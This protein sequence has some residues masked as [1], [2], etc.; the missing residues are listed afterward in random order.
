LRASATASDDTHY[1]HDNDGHD[2]YDNDDVHY[3]RPDDAYGHYS[4]DTGNSAG[5]RT[6]HYGESQQP[7]SQQSGQSEQ[8]WDPRQSASR[9]CT[10]AR[11]CTAHGTAGLSPGW[12]V[13]GQVRGAGKRLMSTPRFPQ[14]HITETVEEDGLLIEQP[15]S[16]PI[17][18]FCGDIGPSWDYD[19]DT[20]E[21]ETSAG[22]WSGSVNGWAACSPCSDMIEADDWESLLERCLKGAAMVGM[23]DR[24][25][26][27]AHLMHQGF[28]QNRHGE[29]RPWG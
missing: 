11:G 29:R 17:C 15:V 26:E 23:A 5:R 16:S 2:A 24:V 18:D 12:H 22:E 7:E 4:G 19:C 28:R 21:V 27:H 8:A 13:H 9:S 20:F 10:A 14:V 1:D 6:S 25:R 3:A